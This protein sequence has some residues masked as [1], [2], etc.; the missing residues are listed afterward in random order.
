M[1]VKTK[2]TSKDHVVVNVIGFYYTTHAPKGDN[3]R[4]Y[5]IDIPISCQ[6]LEDKR[7]GALSLFRHY[8]AH[9]MMP[10]KYPDFSGLYTHELGKPARCSNPYYLRNNVK[11]MNMEQLVEFIEE[12]EL[13]IEEK[14]YEDSGALRAA[15]ELYEKDPDGFRKHQKVA[16]QR[17]GPAL[18]KQD[19]ADELIAEYGE[20]F[21]EGVL[22]PKKS[23]PKD[24]L[25]SKTKL[26]ARSATRY[27]EDEDDSDDDDVLAGV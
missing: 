1:P 13:P 9:R 4:S 11:L 2:P 15:I 27:E 26:R 25:I 20:D 6:D 22:A 23:K 16:E 19:H 7:E 17:K 24:K 3:L 21:I 12:N 8:Y 14:L 10:K 5:D 18:R